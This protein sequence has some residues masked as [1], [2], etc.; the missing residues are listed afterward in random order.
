LQGIE[1]SL[2]SIIGK[3]AKVI[4]GGVPSNAKGLNDYIASLKSTEQSEKSLKKA[5]EER[6]KLIQEITRLQLQQSKLQSE[7][8]KIVTDLKHVGTD[9]LVYA[10]MVMPL[11]VYNDKVDRETRKKVWQYC[12]DNNLFYSARLH[13]DIWGK[14]R[15]I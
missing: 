12:I 11:T 8:G 4:S 10:T 13:V 9:K 2:K 5:Q 7:A 1:K 6:A 15:K 3:S 14:K